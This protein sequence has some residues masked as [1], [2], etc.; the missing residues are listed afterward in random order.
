MGAH[1]SNSVHL[2]ATPGTSLA[3]QHCGTVAGPTY[4]KG[5]ANHL[6]CTTRVVP[7]V[8]T[9]TGPNRLVEKLTCEQVAEHVGTI[10]ATQQLCTPACNPQEPPLQ[11]G[12]VGQ[13]AGPTYKKGNATACQATTKG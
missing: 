11:Y 2:Y 13:A 6:G 9:H 3:Q 12:D 8:C 1:T 4:R 7:H 5:N 10:S